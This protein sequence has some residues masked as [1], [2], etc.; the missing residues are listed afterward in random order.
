MKN[1]NDVLQKQF[2]LVDILTDMVMHFNKRS[3]EFEDDYL[4]REIYKTITGHLNKYTDLISN[5]YS[6][7]NENK[8][9][10]SDISSLMPANNED[11]K[12]VKN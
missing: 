12:I 3:G 7:Q 10:F 1:N 9:S 6:N 4:K 11:N 5:V 8:I 2:E